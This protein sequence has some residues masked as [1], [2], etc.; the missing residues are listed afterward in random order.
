MH[1]ASKRT[2]PALIAMATVTALILVKGGIAWWTGSLAIMASLVDSSLDLLASSANWLAIRHSNQPPDDDH[3]WGHG[4]VESLASLVQA[5]LVSGSAF[6]L[7]WQS[8][9]RFHTPQPLQHLSA[10]MGVMG[11][12]MLISIFLGAF[13]NYSGHKYQ[14]LALRADALHYTSDVWSNGATIAAFVAISNAGWDWLDPVM[15]LATAVIMGKSA[16]DIARTAIHQL[17][18]R[19]LPDDMRQKILEAAL[20][21]SPDV[22]GVHNMRTRQSGRTLIVDLDAEINEH[23]SFREAHDVTQHI[24]DAIKATAGDCI[25]NIHADPA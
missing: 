19:E 24:S 8:F 5:A 13:L 15:C 17:M 22:R 2:V 18:D 25:V 20:S 21:A 12:S 11:A 1:D 3:R 7:I 9:T 16:Y 10:A 4:K 14:S 23:L 6:F